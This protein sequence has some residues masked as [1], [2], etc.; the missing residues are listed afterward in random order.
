MFIAGGK[1]RQKISSEVIPPG[2]KQHNSQT[3]KRRM[4]IPVSRAEEK[5]PTDVV[6]GCF[7]CAERH[8][9]AHLCPSLHD[10][11]TARAASCG[12]APENAIP[13]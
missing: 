11:S 1:K 10:A 7:G 5:K 4:E 6:S 8:L 13:Y 9:S 2:V 12:P 3:V